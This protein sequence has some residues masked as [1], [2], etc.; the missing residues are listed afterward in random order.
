MVIT[1]TWCP[2]FAIETI[3]SATGSGD[4]SI[5]GFLAALFR[6][7]SIEKT[8]KYANCVGNQNLHVLDA[9]SGIKNWD[10]T[11]AMVESGNLKII[12][13]PLPHSDWQFDENFQL[14]ESFW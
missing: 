4:S 3:A 13:L 12:D 2:A 1:G 6:G 10:E 11:T 9:V 8:L 14:W 7:N 5:A